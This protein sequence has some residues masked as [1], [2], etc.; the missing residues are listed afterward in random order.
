MNPPE[1]IVYT[2]PMF[3]SKTTKLL[4]TVDRYRYQN[5]KIE[6]FKP[7]IDNRYAKSDIVTHSGGVLPALTVNKGSEILD[8]VNN[9]KVDVVAV[10]EAFM[11]DGVAE[12][13]K[14]VFRKGI[15]VVVSSLDMSSSCKIFPEM[16]KLMCWATRVEKCPAVCPKCCADAYYTFKKIDDTEEILVG[17][18]DICEPRCWY[19]HPYF[20]RKQDD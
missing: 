6:A 9:M 13:L 3:G 5:K 4:A 7:G 16:E 10:D 20:S 18:A 14:E 1:F 17:G 19:H 12:A 8:C 15:T 11:I 2:G